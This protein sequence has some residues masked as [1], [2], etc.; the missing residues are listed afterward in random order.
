MKY[1]ATVA[2]WFSSF[3]R[4]AVRQ[5]GKPA[6]GHPHRQVLPFDVARRDMLRVGVAGHWLRDAAQA[7]GR[8]VARFVLARCPVELHEH[9]VIYVAAERVL[10]SKA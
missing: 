2:A 5:P 9:R 6:H 4:E 10:N 7:R 8:A 1:R 3:F